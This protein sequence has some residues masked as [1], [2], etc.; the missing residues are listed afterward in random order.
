MT[1]GRAVVNTFVNTRGASGAPTVTQASFSVDLD[2]IPALIGK[3]EEARDKLEQTKFK[4]R[5]LQQIKAPGDDEVSKSMAAALERMAG[6][7]PGGLAWV[8]DKT[9]ERLNTQIN[10]LKAAQQGYRTADENA[11]PQQV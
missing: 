8:V 1:A 3:Y 2:Q 9:I 5:E 11:T 4:A 10:Q 7:E 6:N